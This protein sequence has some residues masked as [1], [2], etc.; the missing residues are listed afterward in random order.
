MGSLHLLLIICIGLVVLYIYRRYENSNMCYVKSTFDSREYMVRNRKD[1]QNAADMLAQIR[2]RVTLL[3]RHM[4]NK[5]LVS[6]DP[7]YIANRPYITRLYNKID[8][9]VI[10]ES[11]ATSLYTSYTLNKGEKIIFCIRSKSLSNAIN[12]MDMHD[13]NLVMYVALHEISHIACPEYNHTTLFK[14][15]F[16]FICE[17]AIAYGIYKKIDFDVS[18]KEYCGMTINDTVV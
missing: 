8:D 11:S 14:Q 16:R 10:V 6:K 2:N 5:S 17:E 13:I 18:P 9:I 12:S 3:A 1:K 7:R 15:I 4:Y